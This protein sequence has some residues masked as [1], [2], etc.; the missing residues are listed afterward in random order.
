M[1]L[2]LRAITK[3]HLIRERPVMM[4]STN[5]VGEIILLRIAAHVLERQ[6]GDRLL[7]RDR[8]RADVGLDHA[9]T[10][11]RGAERAGGG[12][13]RVRLLGSVL[14]QASAELGR[15]GARVR[16]LDEENWEGADLL[17]P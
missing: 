9:T 10:V 13:L 5:P 14:S 12:E 2:E 8:R 1:K 16:R 6:D 15:R 3:S 4:S 17:G 7:S 11:G